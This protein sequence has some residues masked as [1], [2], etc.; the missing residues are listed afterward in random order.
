MNL[1]VISYKGIGYELSR[2]SP[3]CVSPIYWKLYSLEISAKSLSLSNCPGFKQ[4]EFM[5]GSPGGDIKP[6]G[7]APEL[8]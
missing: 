4:D 7:V 8:S 6:G 3:P 1:A 2:Y 5:D